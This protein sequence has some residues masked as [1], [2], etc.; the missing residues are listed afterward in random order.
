MKWPTE[1][2][3]GK[4]QLFPKRSSILRSSAPF[5]TME[6]TEKKP[7]IRRKS[8]GLKLLIPLTIHVLLSLKGLCSLLLTDNLNFP[9][10]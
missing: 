10:Q 7:T 2:D 3:F 5:P 1:K 4:R 8:V 6:V 9:S